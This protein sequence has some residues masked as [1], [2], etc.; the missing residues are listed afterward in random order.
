MAAEHRK[1][2]W[3]PY[4]SVILTLPD[5]EGIYRVWEARRDPITEEIAENVG[6]YVNP[7]KVQAV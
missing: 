5:R 3:L 1:K 2:L 7:G 6:H 4:Q